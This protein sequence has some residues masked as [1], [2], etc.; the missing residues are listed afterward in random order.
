MTITYSLYLSTNSSNNVPINKQNLNNV[1]W[2]I[3]WREIFGSQTGECNVRIKLTSNSSTSLTWANNL[4][5]VRC[6]FVSGHQNA[7]NGFNIGCIQ[8]F[9]DP[10]NATNAYLDC[11]TT[12]TKGLSMTIPSTNSNFNVMI[13]NSS[14]SFMTNIN[15][16]QL[17]LYF[18]FQEKI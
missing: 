12:K 6:N 8:P 7:T 18:D 13:L 2:S 14:E 4:G 10:T 3:N 15:D 5:S 9:T 16:Y 11:D 17:F 1:T